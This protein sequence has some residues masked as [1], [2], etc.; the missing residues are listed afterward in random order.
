MIITMIIDQYGEANNGTT[1]TAMRFA[2]ILRKHGHTVRIVTSVNVKEENV[3]VVKKVN[4]PI[5]TQIVRS[6]GMEWAKPDKEILTKAIEGSDL[7]HFLLPFKIQRKG[8]EIA[9]SLHI[10]TTA[11]FHCPPE[12]FTYTVGL[13]KNRILNKW[14]Y[15]FFLNSFYKKFENIH[16]P[17]EMVKQQL[18]LNGYKSKM[19][20]ISNGVNESFKKSRVEKPQELKDKFVILMVGRLSKEKRQ[21]LT[22]N[23]VSESKYKDKIQLVF[24]GKG[25]WCNH[26]KKLGEKK[27]TNPTIYKFCDKLELINTINYSDLYIHASDAESEGI[28]CME[29]FTC[30]LVPI[31][32]NSEL[33]ATKQFAL[34]DKCLFQ[35]GDHIDLRD[36]ID[37][38]IENSEEK[39]KLS[40]KYVEYS[41]QYQIEN[42]VSAIEKVFQMAIDDNK[43]KWAEKSRPSSNSKLQE[44]FTEK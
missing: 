29:A 19:H 36:K 32:S 22:I 40:E 20:V 11:A 33:V 1:I 15:R 9:D 24:C 8:K 28:S 25:P 44:I 13:G 31:I 26:L 16:C 38:F 35:T 14:L 34:S 6:Q 2:D 37:Y 12:C 30:G 42:C 41:K 10:A 23:A 21:D 17:S 27:L 7:V 18:L 39:E 43:I 5:V 3:F 4:I